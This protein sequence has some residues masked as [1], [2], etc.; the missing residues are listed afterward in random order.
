MLR[1]IPNMQAYLQQQHPGE[2]FDYSALINRIVLANEPTQTS[3]SSR[4]IDPLGREGTFIRATVT[5]SNNGLQTK[6]IPGN[7]SIPKV[8]HLIGS[9]NPL[10]QVGIQLGDYLTEIEGIT[11]TKWTQGIELIHSFIGK[12]PSN[13]QKQIKITIYRPLGDS[14]EKSSPTMEHDEQDTE[15]YSWDEG[16]EN[17]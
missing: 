10:A 17:N 12:T 3:T 13:E 8:D 9:N 11:L 2:F 1:H 14:Q 4:H 6:F 16:T 15:G 5:I 7:A